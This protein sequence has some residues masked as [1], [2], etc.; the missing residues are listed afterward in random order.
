MKKGNGTK[1]HKTA[2]IKEYSLRPIEFKILELVLTYPEITDAEISKEVKITRSNINRIRHKP[3]FIAEYNLRTDKAIDII[4]K[5]KTN[6]VVTIVRKMK[7]KDERVSLKAAELIAGDLLDP[8]RVV[9]NIVDKEQAKKE[10]E[11]M[12]E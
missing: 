8:K 9:I 5:N 4:M 3:A 2:Q 6:A 11:E 10:I 1:Q 12:F 7:S